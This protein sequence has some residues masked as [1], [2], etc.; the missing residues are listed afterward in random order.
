MTVNCTYVAGYE[1]YVK[2]WC[3]GN[4]WKS[5][6][7]VI[8]TNVNHIEVRNDK[9]SIVDQQS[10]RTFS[11]TMM[12]IKAQDEDT[13][14]CGIERAGRDIMYEIKL[15]V[16]PGICRKTWE[17]VVDFP[18]AFEGI[19]VGSSINVSCKEQYEERTL[20]LLCRKE[21]GKFV[22]YP[23]DI[24]KICKAKCN[25][26]EIDSSDVTLD[27]DQEYYDSSTEVTVQCPPGSNPTHN[28]VKCVTDG[29]RNKW[30]VTNLFCAQT[31]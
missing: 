12:G 22:F 10:A 31:S 3:K 4:D 15:K 18:V 1:N 26:T 20:M 8:Q 21:S 11:V 2:Y 27:P 19:T 9:F 23:Q 13:Y 30:N 14:F 16:L 29:Q 24:Q 6:E 5:C 7:I 25:K 28:I 17:D